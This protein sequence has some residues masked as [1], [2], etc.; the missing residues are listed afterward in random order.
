[1]QTLLLSFD[2]KS[3]T[4]AAEELPR[5]SERLPLI[6]EVTNSLDTDPYATM[7]MDCIVL[8]A[9]EQGKYL[10]AT[11][12]DEVSSCYNSKILVE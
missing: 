8:G 4:V 2:S 12:H 6:T 3:V 1:M 10:L 7:N 9:S 11:G 5:A